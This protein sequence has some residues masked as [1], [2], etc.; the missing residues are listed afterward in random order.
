MKQDVNGL[1]VAI[2]IINRDLAD[3]DYQY[4]MKFVSEEKRKRIEKYHFFSDR[5]N[6]LL[7]DILARYEICRRT[8]MTN[9]QLDFSV[10]EYGKPYLVNDPHVQY[11]LSHSGKYIAF[12]IDSK[13]VGIDVEKIDHIDMKIAKRFF[14][15]SE[16]SYINS[17]NCNMQIMSFYQIWTK[18]ESYIKFEGKGLSIPLTSF[19]VISQN[20]VAYHNM[21]E[22][23]DAICTVCTEQK[24]APPCHIISLTDFLQ[25][26]N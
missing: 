24:E 14:T 11:N 26:V 7:A 22:V 2:L 10:N 16:F 18:K 23:D 17:Q 4:F 20:N 8:G 12:A 25:Y 13:P 5:Q 3:K 9:W 19:N 21:L 6:V 15:S 1:E